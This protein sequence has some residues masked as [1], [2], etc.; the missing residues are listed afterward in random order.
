VF[1]VK[2]SDAYIRTAEDFRDFELRL[3]FRVAHM[4]NSGLFLRGDR[5]GGDPAYSGCE[6]QILDDFDWE[7]VTGSKLKD[8][9]FTGSLYGAVPPGDRAAVNPIGLWNTFDVAFRGTR[10]ATALNGRTLYD[11]DTHALAVEPPFRKRV[12]EGF[13][14]LQRHAP[15]DVRGDAYAWFRNLFVRR[16]APEK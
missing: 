9:Q 2:G 15:P 3:D 10:L 13:I 4:A 11:V 16:L 12:P 5:N 6:V 7:R 1:P 8:W 14:G